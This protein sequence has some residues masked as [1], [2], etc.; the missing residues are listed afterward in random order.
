V[1]SELAERLSTI[2]LAAGNGVGRIAIV[3]PFKPEYR[4]AVQ[5]LVE[6][7]PPFDP[8][9]MS[10][11]RHDVFV[12]ER[13]AIFLFEGPDGARIA[14]R[15]VRQPGLWRGALV[16]RKYLSGQP[17]IARQAYAWSHD[18]LD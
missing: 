5:E 16:W 7:G 3:V 2:K 11:E 1:V 10:L 4:V 6:K 12:T 18:L 17:R 8:E 9:L 13:E 14:D 15:I